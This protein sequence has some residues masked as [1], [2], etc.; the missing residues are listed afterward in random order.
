MK[1]DSFGKKSQDSLDFY[2]REFLEYTKTNDFQRD[3][4]ERKEH[5]QFFQ[6][7]LPER[8]DTLSEADVEEIVNRLW[9]HRMW[10]NKAFVA[11]KIVEE[12]S[13]E[14]LRANLKVLYAS[15]DDPEKAYARFVSNVKRWGPASVTE[16]LTYLYPHRC[17]IWN[18]Q[19]RDGLS[20]LGFADTVDL[21]KYVLSADEYRKYNRML[22]SIAKTLEKAGVPDV[23]LLMVD[24]FLYNVAQGR[25]GKTR[26]EVEKTHE[27]SG[28]EPLNGFD[29][30]EIRDIISGIGANLGFDTDTEVRIAHGAQVDVV[31]RARIANLGMVTYVF[32]VHRSGSIDSLILNLQKAYSASTV[33]KVV[34]V[35]DQRQLKKIEAE[36]E[37]LPAQFK[38]ALRYWDVTDIIRIAD[39]LQQVMDSIAELGLLEGTSPGREF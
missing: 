2:V 12:N 26:D 11:Q 1:D 23:D 28:E 18:R 30:N 35:S 17:G 29:H 6:A 25:K 3:L 31:W 22:Q 20:V 38:Q 5:V 21:K 10:G 8:L 24:F 27:L 32:E 16:M 33:Q 4:A 34:A 37:G 39:M 36:C 15:K 19:A 13:L 9:A 14:K 7:Q